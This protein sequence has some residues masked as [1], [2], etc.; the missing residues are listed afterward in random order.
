MHRYKEE[1]IIELTK[2]LWSGSLYEKTEEEIKDN[3]SV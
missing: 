1:D 3:A 2:R